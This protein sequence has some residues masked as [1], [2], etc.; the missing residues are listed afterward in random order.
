MPH[1]T[2]LI[3]IL[4]AGFGLAFLFGLLAVRVRL[5]PLVGYLVAGVALGPFTPGLRADAGLASQL[6]EVGV[7]LLMFGVGLH[8]KVG[9]LLAVRRI[10]VPGA[11]IRI[12]LIGG[13]A[14]I[15]ARAWGWSWGGGVTFGLALAVASTVVVLRQLDA[16]GLLDSADG[17]LAVGW[18]VVEDMAMVLALVLLP[19]LAGATTAGATDVAMDL[20]ITLLKVGAFVVLMLFVGTKSVPWLLARVARTGS[21]ELFTLAVLA[22]ALGVAVGAASLFGVSVALGA[23]AAGVVIAESDLSHQAAADALPLQD[24]FAVLFFVSVGMLFDPRVLLREPVRIAT[25]V[26]IVVLVKAIVTFALLLY[27]RRPMRSAL[28]IATSL[29]QIGEFSFILAGLGITLGVLPAQGRDLIL[30]GALLS[31]VVNPLLV[32]S[33]NAI[34]QWIQSRPRLAGLERVDLVPDSVSTGDY[35]TMREHVV[36][37]G[38]GRVGRRIGDA[39]RRESIPYV[40]VERDRVAVE[41]LRKQGLHAVFGDAARTGILE[42]VHLE[43]ARLLI[44]ASPDPYQARRVTEIARQANPQIEIAARTHSEGGESF[45]RE[46]GADRAFMGERELALSMAHYALVHMGRTDDQAD[47]T[48][49]QMRRHTQTVRLES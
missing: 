48:I 25:V 8:F 23:F 39:L 14:A 17:R 44:I 16:L 49:E 6:S 4:A 3:F 28:L 35:P 45:L 18:L 19:P 42:H 22:V 13:L 2:A 7:I 36:L 26:A 40:V 34:E 29:A 33:I 27:L 47:D 15:I 24:A 43:H 5:P 21:R 31:I 12:A 37:I 38:Y 1:D 32:R 9:D 11:L 46:W 20:A 10:A 30:A 41:A